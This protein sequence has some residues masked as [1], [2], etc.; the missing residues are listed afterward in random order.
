MAWAFHKLSKRKEFNTQQVQKLKKIGIKLIVKLKETFLSM[1]NNLVLIQEWLSSSKFSR[2]LIQTKEELWWKVSKLQ[3][4]PFYQPIGMMSQRKI[5]KEETDH[6]H[7][8]VKNGRKENFDF[9]QKSLIT[10]LYFE[11]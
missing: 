1:A 10:I 7:L 5:M 4:E 9:W 8:K 3:E 2:M 6:H 11:K